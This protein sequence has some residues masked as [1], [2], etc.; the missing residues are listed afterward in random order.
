MSSD[1]LRDPRPS[2]WPPHI[3]KVSLGVPVSPHVSLCL[4]EVDIGLAADVG[5][6]QRLPEIMGSQ[7]WVGGGRQR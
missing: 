7:R 2:P 3:P 4:Q 5:T 1:V 6:L